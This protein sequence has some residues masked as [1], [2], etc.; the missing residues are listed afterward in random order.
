MLDRLGEQ[1]Q[2]V[3]LRAAARA[4]TRAVERTLSNRRAAPSSSAAPGTRAFT[5]CRA[6]GYES[7]DGTQR[8][9]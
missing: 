3:V 1:R 7:G 8:R 6:L 4:I 9:L 5:L 2:I